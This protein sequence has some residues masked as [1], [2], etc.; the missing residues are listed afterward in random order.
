[1]RGGGASVGAGAVVVAVASWCIVAVN[2]I[3]TDVAAAIVV[4]VVA[5][6]VTAVVVAVAAAVAAAAHVRRLLLVLPSCVSVHVVNYRMAGRQCCVC[7][8][9]TLLPLL[10]HREREWHS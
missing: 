6:V 7:C 1:M 8:A 9:L 4:A 3:G 2:A 10:Y 5:A